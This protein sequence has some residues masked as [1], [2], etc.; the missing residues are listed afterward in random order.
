MM[1]ATTFVE[2]EAILDEGIKQQFIFTHKMCFTGYWTIPDSLQLKLGDD[3]VFGGAQ[4]RKDM[5]AFIKAGA[6]PVYVGWGNSEIDGDWAVDILVSALKAAGLRGIVLSGTCGLG[7]DLL[8][9]H[10]G[11]KDPEGL[12]KYAQ[13]NVLFVRWAPYDWL[14]P[15]CICAMLNGGE[16]VVGACLRTGLPMVMSPADP[17]NHHHAD[18]VLKI[19][20]GTKT[21]D[22]ATLE[23]SEL[24]AALKKVATK[25]PVVVKAA[26][27]INDFVRGEMGIIGAV[28]G[29]NAIIKNEVVSGANKRAWEEMKRSFEE[30]ESDEEP[31][32]CV[33]RPPPASAQKTLPKATQSSETVTPEWLAPDGKGKILFLTI[34]MKGHIIHLI[35]IAQWFTEHPSYEVTM[36]CSTESVPDIPKGCQIIT[37]KHMDAFS[38]IDEH[39]ARQ[40]NLDVDEAPATPKEERPEVEVTNDMHDFLRKSVEPIVDWKP[41]I[42]IADEALQYMPFPMFIPAV[43]KVYKVKAL[44]VVSPSIKENRI[45]QYKSQMKLKKQPKALEEPKAQEEPQAPA[46]PTAREEPQTP[47]APKASK[48]AEE[49]AVSATDVPEPKADVAEEQSPESWMSEMPWKPESMT[50]FKLTMVFRAIPQIP[51]DPPMLFY[52]SSNVLHSCKHYKH[53]MFTGAFLPLPKPVEGVVQHGRSAFTK[54]IAP[55][56]LDWIFS[57]N[58]DPVVYVA[59]G[60]IVSKFLNSTFVERLVEA[61]DGGAWRVILVL[62]KA[63]QA[64]LP[65]GLDESRWRVESFAPQGEIL[66]CERT[67]CFIS[68]CGANSTME[69]V[70]SGVPLVCMPFYMDQFDWSWT[71]RRGCRAG[72]QI[73]CHSEAS[74]I[75]AAV[76]EVLTD[77]S[78]REAALAISHRMARQSDSLMRILGP[79]MAPKARLG[80]GVSVTAAVIIALLKGR[81]PAEVTELLGPTLDGF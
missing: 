9:T 27:Q 29:V 52:P 24:Q 56:L 44:F 7:M 8:R 14:F 28:I 20:M 22:V 73:D 34:P 36:V 21:S 13:A 67:R 1:I 25:D 61:L 71:V 40:A 74:V 6:P 58:T 50:M 45:R 77:S 46:E 78:Y 51:A 39:L 2:F 18:W 10:V 54:T 17:L 4:A 30:A 47:A 37:Y 49:P 32:D 70:S 15:K 59:F 31:D 55:E 65:S 69:S 81:K 38:E 80:P 43:C 76:S 79:G 57:E 16:A 64:F 41:D 26:K 62:P 11:S 42:F 63:L 33:L 68:H 5:E 66:R 19:G 35:R 72:V 23:K 3:I 12:C 48:E 60:T 53:E 75:R